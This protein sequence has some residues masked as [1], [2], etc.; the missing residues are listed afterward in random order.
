MPLTKNYRRSR[1]NRKRTFRKRRTNYSKTYSIAKSAAKR[2]IN[3]QFEKHYFDYNPDAF[4]VNTSGSIEL[5]SAIP[6]GDSDASRSGDRVTIKSIQVKGKLVGNDSSN[7]IRVMLIQ[8]LGDTGVAAPV[9]GEI[10]QSTGTQLAPLSPYTKDFAGYKWVPLY[11][12]LYALDLNNSIK[13]FDIMV[14]PKNFKKKAK[15]FIQYQA[16]STNNAIGQL[17][18]VFVSDGS[19]SPDVSVAMYSR[20]RFIDN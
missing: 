9:I 19:F 14:T 1:P 5:L 4:N 15:P 16:G 11:D 8:Y 7:L 2:V 13:T 12:A 20:I 18:M 17:Y 10:F 3:N 6:V